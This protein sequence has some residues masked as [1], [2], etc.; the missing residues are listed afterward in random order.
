MPGVVLEAASAALSAATALRRLL[1]GAGLLPVRTLPAPVISVGNLAAGGAGK[2]P[3]VEHAAGVLSSLGAR[4]V[5]L[6]RGYGGPVGR[7]GLNDEGCVLAANLPGL[8]QVQDPDRCAAGSRAL[9]AGLGDC[10]LLDDGFQHFRLARDLDVVALDARD[11]FGGRLRREGRGGLRRAGFVVLTRAGRATA[12]ELA[13]ARAAAA[14]AAGESV[15]AA[16]HEPA[17]LLPL[18]GGPPEPASSLRGRAVFACA[19]I[20]DPS[21]LSH[22]LESLGARVLGLRGFPDHGLRTPADLAPAFEEARARGAEGIVVTQKDA[23]KLAAAG[24]GAL[25]MPVAAL[26]VRLRFLDGED[27]FRDALAGALARGRA[28][29][30]GASPRGPGG[31]ARDPA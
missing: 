21:A 17:D 10:L 29:A 12:A 1:H 24:G 13:A 19:G 30:A 9:A 14:A 6:A 11:P 23:V 16:D 4:P 28:R 27:R 7:T 2:T 25:P 20:A 22:T 15:A 5:V 3:L 31:P 8:A 26:R 18:G